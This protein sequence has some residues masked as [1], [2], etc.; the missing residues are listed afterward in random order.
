MQ[1]NRDGLFYKFLVIS[2]DNIILLSEVR[3]GYRSLDVCALRWM[4][5]KAA[6]V[7]VIMGSM[8][9]AISTLG[10]IA[11]SDFI[12]FVVSVIMFGFIV[13]NWGAMAVMVL[14]IVYVFAIAGMLLSKSKDKV[15]ESNVG[16]MYRSWRDKYCEKVEIV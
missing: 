6:G 1:L 12:A 10:A 2:D 3:R 16:V 15:A 7:W 8:I 14:G 4:A 11:I 5:V 9:A 13:P